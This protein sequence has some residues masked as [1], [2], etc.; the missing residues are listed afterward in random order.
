MNRLRVLPWVPQSAPIVASLYME[1]LEEKALSTAP[2]PQ[3][4]AQ[5]CG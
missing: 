5:V 4:L 2:T 1:Y 3:V